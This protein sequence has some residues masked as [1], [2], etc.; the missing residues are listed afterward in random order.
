MVRSSR[1]ASKQRSGSPYGCPSEQ[2][3]VWVTDTIR[4]R[5]HEGWLYPAVVL[6]EDARLGPDYMRVTAALPEDNARVVA[7]LEARP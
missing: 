1:D 4:I 6:D 3:R 7:A 5:T 2:N